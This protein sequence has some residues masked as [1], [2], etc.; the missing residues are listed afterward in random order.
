M[1]SL[2][3]ATASNVRAFH[4][5]S[6]VLNAS[7][8]KWAN[9][10]DGE[11]L[12][13]EVGRFRVWSGNLGALQ[14]GHSSLD[15][16]LRDSP[17]LSNNAL[18]FLQELEDNLNE[19]YAI[20]SGARLPYEQLPKQENPEI[21][22]EDD[23]FYSEDENEEEDDSGESRTELRMR[24][25]DITD[26]IDNL[27]KLSVRI[28][29]PTI[30]SRSLKAASYKPTDPETG[31]DILSTY[32][33]YDLRHINEL[34]LHLR[35]PY[36]AD[37][38]DEQD[39][40][41][42]RLSAAIT[43]R[44]R[45]FKYWRRHRDKLG[46][47]TISE[48]SPQPIHSIIE[49]PG[50]L[51]ND[52]LE[53][54]PENP[55]IM[56]LKEAPSQ[57]TG[58][59]LISGTEATHHHQSLDEVVD[60]KSV[61]SYA[62][63]VKDIHGRGVDLP[64]P[65]KAANGDKDFECPYC[66]IICPA[67][68]GRGRAWR[69]HLLQDLQ[70]YSCTYP[71]CDGSEQLFRSRR[72]WAAHEASHR[73]V[74]RCPEHPA[75]VYK[76]QAGLEDH[77][78]RKHLDSFPESQLGTIVKV[79]E[80]STVDLRPKC[81]ICYASADMDGLGDFQNH[82]ANH[83]ERIATFALPNNMEDDSNGASSAA[84]RGRS[85]SSGSQQL[86]EMSLPSDTTNERDEREKGMIGSLQG[87]Q[88]S[89]LVQRVDPGR[90]LLSAES[91][92]QLSDES[93]NRLNMIA[94]QIGDVDEFDDRL[95][96][97]YLD[98]DHADE[99]PA[100]RQELVEQREAFRKYMMSLPGVE[101]VR[102]YR[103][104]GSGAGQVNFID[105]AAGA[106]AMTLFEPQRFPDIKVQSKENKRNLSKWKFAAL[107]PSQDTQGPSIP[108][109]SADTQTSEESRSTSLGSISYEGELEKSKKQSILTIA[110]VPTLRSLYRSRRLLQRDQSYAPNDSYNQIVSFCYHDLT[111]LKVDAIVN[112]ANSAMKPTKDLNT[113]N[114][115]IHRVGGPKLTQEAKSKAKL[116]PGQVEMTHGHNLPS[117]W[118][119]HAARPIYFGSRGMDQFNILTECY[120]STL[121]MASNNKIKTLAFP[122]LGT[123]GASF[124]TRV[125]ARMALQE[126]REYL[127]A[128]TDHNFERIIF[129]VNSALDERAY[130]NFLPVVFPPT[131]GDL[132]RARTSDWSPNRAALVAQIL[133]TRAQVQKV[134][135]DL[136]TEFGPIVPNLEN[137]ILSDLRGIDAAL[138]SIRSFLLGPKQLKRSLGDLNLLCSV[139]L[140][141]CGSITETTELAK[142][143]ATAGRTSKEIWDEYN[144]HMM[145]MHEV[146]LAKL[147]EHCRDFAQCLDGILTREN[148]ELDAMSTLR[149]ILE[150]YGVKQK[151]Q[152]TEGIR[153]H[154]DEVLYTR[155]FQREAAS[156]TRDTVRLHQ[157]SSVS[158][159]YQFGKLEAK[160]TLARPSTIFNHTVCLAREDITKLEVDI[161]VNSTDVLFLGMGTLDRSV[162]KKGGF[163]LREQVKKFGRCK[164]GDVK[165]TQ[166][167]FLPAKHILHVIPPNQY[168]KNTK[169][170]LRS[171]YRE[172]LLTAM[173]MKATSVAIPSIGTGMLNY[174][175]RDCASLAIEEVK[176]FLESIEANNPIEKIIFVVYS[177]N[178][179]FIYKSLLPIYFPP[180][181]SDPTQST[182][183]PTD[184]KEGSSSSRPSLTPR[185]SL[186]ESVGEAIRNVRFGKQPETSR[187][188]NTY[189]ENT[190]I[191]F[192]MHAKGCST[193]QDI[194]R[195]YLEGRDLCETG[196]ALA[197]TLLWHLDMSTDGNVYS[198]SDKTGKRDRLDIPSD[199]FPLSLLL[200]H[201]VEKSFR[202]E[203]RSRPFVNQHRHHTA[204]S[205]NQSQD[206]DIPSATAEDDTRVMVST[207]E[208]PAKIE[209]NVATWSDRIACWEPIV[210]GDCRVY[211]YR[212]L[213]EIHESDAPTE[214][215]V[216]LL[217]M[218]L[219]PSTTEVHQATRNEVILSGAQRLESVLQ[220]DGPISFRSSESARSDAIFSVLQRAVKQSSTLGRTSG[221]QHVT[222]TWRDDNLEPGDA[223]RFLEP[224]PS[225]SKE[226][227]TRISDYPPDSTPAPSAS[228]QLSNT[229]EAGETSLLTVQ[230]FKHLT[231]D[232]KSRPGSYVGQNTNDIASALNKDP[233]EV[234]T[235]I[236]EL[237]ARKQVHNTI[238]G[239][240]WVVSHPPKELPTLPQQQKQSET[241]SKPNT[242]LLL[243]AEILSYM[244]HRNRTPAEQNG[245][246]VRELA[247]ALQFPT[248]DIWH[249]IREL[250]ARGKIYRPSDAE[251]WAVT[252]AQEE[253]VPETQRMQHE[254]E[255]WPRKSDEGS[256][257]SM[258][259]ADVPSLNIT[260]ASP[261]LK[262]VEDDG[263]PYDEP[264]PF[265]PDLEWTPQLDVYSK[266]IWNYVTFCSPASDGR[267]TRIDKRL[268]DTEVLENLEYE[269]LEHNVLVHRVLLMDE[270]HDLV[271]M[272][273]LRRIGLANRRR[274]RIDV[275]KLVLTEPTTIGGRDAADF[276]DTLTEMGESSTVEPPSAISMEPAEII[277]RD[278]TAFEDTPPSPT[279][280]SAE[281]Q[282]SPE[283]STM[284]PD[285]LSEMIGAGD[286]YPPEFGA[287]WTRI[288]QRL[289]D[290]QVLTEAGED[291]ENSGDSLIVHRVLRRGE[292]KEW[293][294]RTREIRQAGESIQ[295]RVER[296]ER[297][298]SERAAGASSSG[299]TSRDSGGVR[300]G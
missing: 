14:K 215:Q 205:R 13:D 144:V 292:I 251:T 111:R 8:S 147:L 1:S 117:S 95:D 275:P 148:D 21:D 85:G 74:W 300:E 33:E 91:L 282:P 200:L 19:A 236:K 244:E 67:R 245:L 32:A 196:Y 269:I 23:G 125:A 114:N 212:T 261:E 211:I 146:R 55:I 26:I 190:L 50:P 84:S 118:V 267:W 70:P 229:K 94:D 127:E 134:L 145:D 172:V 242:Q 271:E 174:P 90:T 43:L 238:D 180:P 233:N 252:P 298:V 130:M 104:Y 102:F 186:F 241:R 42:A 160:P 234:Y 154:L 123:G 235:A 274:E 279:S 193:C 225:Q 213:I 255:T 249:A 49:R 121:E 214:D 263:N 71:D 141:V 256:G 63:T 115:A 66:Y 58:K 202:D 192:E 188:I 81:P 142:D 5:L 157:L 281:D 135:D 207:A 262:P 158:R 227:Q 168:G 191:G 183:Q 80:T 61:T 291:F 296:Y 150:S 254:I 201:T 105:D 143:T 294:D 189:E 59:T 39:F 167:Y 75:A 9:S 155:E 179:E 149:Q 295:R 283:P 40:L 239:S 220:Y 29:T 163:E 258:P 86:S 272:T 87:I 246:T 231:N 128:H 46:A 4:N 44:R 176:R 185:R 257:P 51:R 56:A 122:C 2:R 89:D 48:E 138:A 171:I 197:Q 100:D 129:C 178:D 62:V 31:I 113:L 16:R 166:G 223:F 99:T 54:H 53:A 126:V 290:T 47:S 137:T 37:V 173:L 204:V 73:K 226:E 198:K 30:R 131:H 109:S 243:A 83:L 237:V 106:H 120:R 170:V 112:S 22:D 293:A 287:H 18:K 76:S 77:L 288:D 221:P 162:F 175:R 161:M 218:D 45:Q 110:D 11:A 20:V 164:E 209:A 276:E 285:L 260:S 299:G 132:D 289:V 60:T 103:R 151:G 284:D 219:T 41:V 199:T 140:T 273:R 230:I 97:Q 7:D 159:L 253:F 64:P 17:L 15:Y 124:P 216:P 65:P 35:Q 52:T 28:R 297:R 208:L 222:Q 119:I 277:V 69:T 270:I 194:D 181:E 278:A 250:S 240:T 82:I 184:I 34:L 36:L 38:Q 187:P 259:T 93:Q 266:D 177:S 169:D 136:T 27:Y 107:R 79:G 156:Y 286:F 264:P 224:A 247:S 203:D 248:M 228:T 206:D 101:T 10:I 57:K 265:N 88:P 116:K 96:D 139:M 6:N 72:E 152:D 268:V 24:L 182:T 195:L 153:D 133:E 210:P 98:D 92:H 232:L 25:E 108:Q 68:Y 165:S 280:P 217:S 3:I 12:D 78:R